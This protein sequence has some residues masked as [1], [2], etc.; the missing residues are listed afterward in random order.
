MTLLAL[1]DTLAKGDDASQQLFADGQA[2]FGKVL[3]T[4]PEIRVYVDGAPGMESQATTVHVLKRLIDAY[5]Y[6]G[7]VTVIYAPAEPT[8]GTTPVPTPEKLAL[9]LSG[10]DPA[11][12]DTAAVKYGSCLT[13]KFAPVGANLTQVVLG[14]TG[15]ATD[16]KVDL[17]KT[18]DAA[19]VL[20]LQPYL[21]TDATGTTATPNRAELSGQDPIDLAEQNDKLPLL[22]YRYDKDATAS[23]SDDVW[24]WYTSQ[25]F[26][27]GLAARSANAQ[28]LVTALAAKTNASLWPASGLDQFGGPAGAGRDVVLNLALAGLS[29]QQQN[30]F[31]GN[32]IVLTLLDDLDP[33]ALNYLTAFQKGQIADIKT[34]LMRAYGPPAGPAKAAAAISAVADD[35]TALHTLL[36][37]AAHLTIGAPGKGDWITPLIQNAK[38]GDMVLIPLGSVPAIVSDALVASAGMPSAFVGSASASLPVTTGLP[39]LQLP[40]SGSDTGNYPDAPAV[41]PAVS[42]EALAAAKAAAT[43]RLLLADVIQTQGA[44]YKANVTAVADFIAACYATGP[45]Q[46]YFAGLATYYGDDQHDKLTLALTLLLS[47]LP[48]G[49]GLDLDTVYS[50]LTAAWDDASSSV[51][52]IAALP[53]SNLAAYYGAVIA[54]G[55]LT[56]RAPSKDYIYKTTDGG[57]T[58]AVVIGPPQ[59]QTEPATTAAFQIP[60]DVQVCFTAS[61]GPVESAMTCRLDDTWELPGAPWVGLTEP[62]FDLTVSEAGIPVK[63]GVVGTIKDTGLELEVD[64]PVEQGM[65]TMSA[66]VTDGT[67]SLAKVFALAGGANLVQM[68]PPPL[69]GIAT[70]GLER[71][72]VVYDAGTGVIESMVFSLGSSEPWV[73]LHDPQ[74][75]IEPTLDV[76]VYRPRDLKNRSYRFDIGGTLQIPAK[77]GNTIMVSARYPDF[78]LAA[79]LT[80]GQI[81]IADLLSLFGAHVDLNAAVTVFALRLQPSIGQYSLSTTVGTSNPDDP[82]WKVPPN[83]PKFTIGALGFRAER[84]QSGSLYGFTGSTVILPNSAKIE[85]D[86]S[87]TWTTDA[88]WTF[89]AVVPD[90]DPNPLKIGPLLWEY[91]QWDVGNDYNFGVKGLTLGVTT[92]AKQELMPAVTN[93]AKQDR[94]LA[95]TNGAQT[96]W[97]FTAATDGAWSIPFLPE[98]KL[99]ASVDIANNWGGVTGSAGKIEVSLKGASGAG[100]LQYVDI[101]VAYSYGGDAPYQFSITWGH[102]TGT[103]SGRDADGDRV[104]TLTLKDETVGSLIEEMVSWITGS[105]FSLDPPWDALDKLSLD[106]LELTYTFND[107]DSTKNAIGLKIPVGP[108]DLGFCR[109]DALEISY[110][111][112]SNSEV[113][114]SGQVASA[115]PT[116]GVMITIDGFF[117]WNVDDDTGSI[118]PW[119]TSQP[120]EAPAPPGNGNKYFDVRMLALGQ[121]IAVPGLASATDVQ[122][123]I[124]ALEALQPPD[125]DT[126]PP[127]NFD[128]SA[129]WLVGAEF[130]ILK[131]GDDENSD[132]G[133]GGGG[134][135]GSGGG[136]LVAAARGQGADDYFLT[137]QFV[138]ADPT[139]YGLRIALAGK[140]A[141]ILAGLDFQIM[142]R[143]VSPTVGVYQAELTLPDAARHLSVGAYSITLPVIAVAV[144]TNGNFLIDIGFP[145]NADFSRSL[146]ISGIIA[147]GIPVTGSAGLYFGVL[148]SATTDKVPVTTLGTFNPVVVFGFGLQVGFGA[149]V[150]YGIL[151]AGFSVTVVGILEGVIGKFNPYQA[152]PAPGGDPTQIQSSYYF[153]LTGAVGVIGKLYGTIDFAVVKADVNLEVKL[154]LT[155]TYESYVSITMTVLASVDVSVSISID[156][157]LFSITLHFSF[158]MQLKETFTIENQGTPPWG[159]PPAAGASKFST[160]PAGILRAPVETRISHLASAALDAAA[161][162]VEPVWTNLAAPSERATLTGYFAPAL[163]LARD[164][165]GSGSSHVC[166]VAMLTLDSMKQT[167]SVGSALAADLTADFSVSAT[168]AWLATGRGEAGAIVVDVAASGGYTGNVTL[169]ASGLDGATIGFSPLNNPGPGTPQLTLV[170]PG[171]AQLLVTPAAA[172]PGS[173]YTLTITGQDTSGATHNTTVTLVVDSSF[174]VLCKTVT[175]WVL[176]AIKGKPVTAAQLDAEKV[177]RAELDS[178]LAVTLRSSDQSPVPIPPSVIETFLEQQFAVQVGLPDVTAPNEATAAFFPAPP[179]LSIAVPSAS[180]QYTIGE[181]NSITDTGLAEIRRYFDA[182]AV[183]V[184]EEN[185][186]QTRAAALTGTTLS[187]GSWL[188]ADYFLMLARQLVQALRSGLRDYKYPIEPGQKVS[189]VVDDVNTSSGLDGAF[190]AADLFTANQS[191]PLQPGKTLTV[192]ITVPP[193]ADPRALRDLTTIA[194]EWRLTPA[195]L[196]GANALQ[197]PLLAQGLTLSYADPGGAPAVEH[198]IGANDTLLSI[199][200]AFATSAKVKVSFASLLGNTSVVTQQKQLE[201]P[202]LLDSQ[203]LLA[204]DA[205]IAVPVVPYRALAD[206]SFAGIAAL[207]QFGGSFDGPVLAQANAGIS[208]LVTGTKIVYGNDTY[209]VAA[210]D[211]LGDVANHFG[212]S[213]PQLLTDVPTLLTDAVI[214][215]GAVLA[216]PTFSYTTQAADTLGQV[217]AAFG[218]EVGLLGDAVDPATA[219]LFA[220]TDGSTPAPYLDV[221]HLPAY[222][223]GPL[224][225]EAQRSLAFQHLA[226]MS[227]RF[228][229]HGLRLPTDQ[230]TPL[231]SGMWVNNGKLPAAAGLYA[232]TGQQLPI[233]IPQQ[234]WTA[235][236][237]VAT[238]GATDAWLTLVDANKQPTSSI[239]FVIDPTTQW[240]EQDALRA[241][242]LGG[243]A[244]PLDMQL[245][246]LGAGSMAESHPARFALASSITWQSPGALDMPYGGT[247]DPQALRIWRL[248]DALVNLPDPATRAQNPVF[249]PQ[250]ARF[251]EATGGTVT[252]PIDTYAWATQVQFTIKRVPVTGSV[253]HAGADTYQ[254][255]G[256]ADADVVLLERIVAQAHGDDALFERVIVAYPPQA[257]G[258]APEGVQTDP[259]PVSASGLPISVTFGIAQV[260]LSTDTAPPTTTTQT[261]MLAQQQTTALGLLNGKSEFVELLWEASITRDGGFY[262]FYY[263]QSD[264]RGIPD[265]CFDDQGQ[266]TLTLVLIYSKPPADDD[267]DRLTNY[268]N[269]LVTGT[270]IDP[271]QTMVF[272]EAVLPSGPL[273]QVPL[274]TN[275][276][277]GGLAHAYFSDPGDLAEVN[278][279]LP[280]AAGAQLKIDRGTFQA[281]PGGIA[282]SVVAQQF[283]TTVAA[284]QA[285][286]PKGSGGQPPPLPDP[287]PYPDAINLPLLTLVAGGSAHTASIA[288]VAGAYGVSV[289][290]V[291]A[292]NLHVAP[293]FAATSGGV[294]TTVAIPGGPV[295]RGATVPVGVESLAAERPVPAAVP[296][297]SDPGYA[298]AFLQNAYSLLGCQV[299]E[300]AYFKGSNFGVPIGPTTKPADPSSNDKLRFA[301]ALSEGDPWEYRRAVPYADMSQE[302]GTSP[303]RGVG[304]LLQVSFAFQDL[305]G[306]LLSTNLSDPTATTEP[307]NQ[308]PLRLGYTDPIVGLG[309]WPG[310]GASYQVT[311]TTPTWQIALALSFDT[312][313]YRG[314]LALDIGTASVT[315]TFTG[316]V[317]PTTGADVANYT[318]T[319]GG[320]SVHPIAATLAPG[321]TSVL[322]TFAAFTAGV[323][324]ALEVKG[325]QWPSPDRGSV[326][327]GGTFTTEGVDPNSV[328]VPARARADLRAYDRLEAQMRDSHGMAYAVESTLIG[329]DGRAPL[330]ATGVKS[331]QDWLFD[332]SAPVAGYLRTVSKGTIPACAPPDLPLA[333]DP[334]ALTQLN[335][336][337]IFELSTSFLMT[338]TGGV[339]E[340]D[341]ETTPGIRSSAT[342]VAPYQ[343]TLPSNQNG[344]GTRALDA[345]A[346]GFEQALKSVADGYKL[347]V[348]TGLDRHKVTTVSS[349]STLWAVRIGPSAISYSLVT[350]RGGR[351]QSTIFAPRPVSTTLQNRAAVPIYDYATG[352][353]I[354][355]TS[356]PVDFA[357]ID[358][359]GWC[360][361]LFEAVDTVLAPEY[362]AA[363][364]IVYRRSPVG[365]TSYLE[366]LLT[367]KQSLATTASKLMAPVFTPGAKS[368]QAVAAFYQSLLVRLSN[369]YAVRAAIEYEAQVKTSATTDD[370]SGVA[371]RLFGAVTTV[372]PK[373]LWAAADPLLATSITVQFDDQMAVGPATTAANYAILPAGRLNVT[374]VVPLSQTDLSVFKVN[375]SGA[376]TGTLELEVSDAVTNTNGEPL[377]PPLTLPILAAKPRQTPLTFSS[378][379]LPLASG[380]QPLTFLLS[381][382][383]TVVGAG[384]EVVSYVD[385]D[386]SYDGTAIEHQIEPAVDPDSAYVASSW[387]TFLIPETQWP[388]NAYLGPETVPMILRDYPAVPSLPSQQGVA[389]GTEDDLTSIRQW[390]YSFTYSLP[391]HYP[392]D[393]VDGKVE[394][395][396]RSLVQSHA[397]F[398]DAFPQLA[399]FVTQYPAIAADLQSYLAL[400]DTTTTDAT[401]LTNATQAANAFAQLVEAVANVASGHVG[402]RFEPPAPGLVGSTDLTYEFHVD[403]SSIEIAGAEALLVKLT[404]ALP[405]GVASA[406]V[407]IAG[408]TAVP[409]PG[410]AAEAD[411]SPFVYQAKNGSYL[412]AAVG[413]TIANRT[414]ELDGLDILQRQDA[415]PSVYIERNKTLMPDARECLNDFVYTTPTITPTSPLYPTIDS[416]DAIL[417]AAI[418][419][420]A[421]P[422]PPLPR[423]L[424]AQFTALFTALLANNQR[425]DIFVQVQIDYEYSLTADLSPLS[426]PVL[427]QPPLSV[428]VQAGATGPGSLAQMISDWSGAIETWFK[429]E[430]PLGAGTLWV[431]LILLSDL[432]EKPMPL[433]RL[434]KLYLPILYVS[435]PLASGIASELSAR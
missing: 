58:N 358:L 405:P 68:L 412:S 33:S 30:A 199:A 181:F 428:D 347:K 376:P 74:L 426:L 389:T 359:D 393:R 78:L 365:Q 311:G 257:T 228:F 165:W 22:P 34:S 352:T 350:D 147:P 386:L 27:A 70:F 186:R 293:I 345:F 299:A 69:N 291:A 402:L 327:G 398:P 93:G 234:I 133:N 202:R 227:S 210:L 92:G 8:Y 179:G 300:N 344:N 43:A 407:T 214:A 312:S 435:P 346:R 357:G 336:A 203:A 419:E 200:A 353:G 355:G 415:Q 105:K 143:Q 408:F 267:Q 173:S 139:L 205:R 225:E 239:A 362:T 104:A 233:P 52:L 275:A 57:K 75:S 422:P 420:P 19:Q 82:G 159:L 3:T 153:A 204:T 410:V 81:Q 123:A 90:Q 215:T 150:D 216:L 36:N 2:A 383:D 175:R 290:A 197:S 434:R 35:L 28:K 145:W 114:A 40:D 119:D 169:S 113:A 42:T 329:G 341:L 80:D 306:N 382:P 60:F 391:F 55:K 206:A 16:L 198:Q 354:S 86:V 331:L 185:G 59:G 229:F 304:G 41:E 127:V 109:I 101:K 193:P 47:V 226:A 303:Y 212:L 373:L 246:E 23:V 177:S 134:N 208:L 71:V 184:A 261:G 349:G 180:W 294:A 129:G 4:L 319:S 154:L 409:P 397:G 18:L 141:K 242:K 284:L 231:Q 235:P 187:L 326:V 414:I 289:R 99:T 151:K 313:R 158:S 211:C 50:D 370:T 259:L 384:G 108:I 324:Y 295:V 247:G 433:L 381:A 157:G 366:R 430:Q 250:L 281:P 222:L 54:D 189:D 432:T 307:L 328:T 421:P 249:S 343:A 13:I 333:T 94:T 152:L 308:P 288:D 9:L 115:E 79:T 17:N 417:I 332:G 287:L 63:G 144:Y 348:A 160:R 126:I 172:T 385:L 252:A 24:T 367:A 112:K 223:I 1:Q 156:V 270:G 274:P 309:Q 276:S 368:D 278:Q 125:G 236:F 321:N 406:T 431:D 96:G 84:S 378:P 77:A 174:D 26:D 107:K 221:P 243:A 140:P 121:H 315:V 188:F 219:D 120:G 32:A 256:V 318:L 387:L 282:L 161:A 356:H 351:A 322:L 166:A 122:A 334:L 314:V 423:S 192:G 167:D 258:A 302:S 89:E 224:I 427:M 264:K 286:N 65:W 195:L 196:A 411:T 87:A 95:V 325:V 363:L 401:T 31:A 124:A 337:D 130:A 29:Y 399:E 12:I 103:L 67:V 323:T 330:G 191:H 100:I 178:L 279:E 360:R 369:A 97:H 11:Q 217:A 339:V 38:A 168:P 342:V 220:T 404:G 64:Y 182:L 73:F 251:D 6:A 15:S 265:R 91:L 7:T 163:T 45:Q 418:G 392:Q 49:E 316:P 207:P 340:A 377:R 164:E 244:L 254:L 183:Q 396:M 118:G 56:I 21:S 272:T 241:F 39:Y 371:P 317:D 131:L 232:L 135:G 297:P 394:F 102:L 388:L 142:Y 25:T 106:G 372:Q 14:I 5:S 260:N 255:V 62:G 277:I 85:V 305:Y 190:T 170:A 237:T 44:S 194:T 238:I 136:A 361:R 271:T 375:L 283:G 146:T 424:E 374:S 240:G 310:V 88:G 209:E 292:A 37:P 148:S 280:L 298:V 155:L 53:K 245:T 20:R 296:A 46:D 176:A 83:H 51:D 400:V 61:L 335:P 269:A 429:T 416:A 364:Q 117:P 266:A 162:V 253:E 128:A 72:Q 403:E 425:P 301:P 132:G 413:Q 285:A 262:L 263:D 201:W 98:L 213:V 395:N 320:T 379:K 66:T 338:R 218:I 76:T 110:R 48:P 380:V 10:L 171:A 149:D 111:S 248:P 116:P 138:F 390:R 273:P 230:L 268:M 137:T